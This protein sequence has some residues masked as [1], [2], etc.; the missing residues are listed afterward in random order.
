MKCNFSRYRVRA[1]EVARLF[2]DRPTTA[3]AD[4]LWWTEYVVRHKG[5]PHLRP[6]GADMPLHQYLLLDVVAFLLSAVLSVVLLLGLLG[7]AIVK[8]LPAPLKPRLKQCPKQK[9]Y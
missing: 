5:A 1:R 7:R 2:S 4:A 8:R 3:A 9:L 6:L